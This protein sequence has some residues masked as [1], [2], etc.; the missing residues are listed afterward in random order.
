MNTFAKK[1]VF[2]FFA[3]QVGAKDFLLAA[4][5]SIMLELREIEPDAVFLA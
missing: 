3:V 5:C 1:N 2:L 4:N